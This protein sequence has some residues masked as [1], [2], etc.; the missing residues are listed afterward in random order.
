LKWYSFAFKDRLLPFY[1]EL[2]VLH[3]KEMVPSPDI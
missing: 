2:L 1:F 3:L